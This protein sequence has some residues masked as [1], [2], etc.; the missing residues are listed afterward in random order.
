ME[1]SSGDV[2]SPAAEPS[3]EFF[4]HNLLLPIK[5]AVAAMKSDSE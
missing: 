5:A 3:I 2:M 1:V 4:S